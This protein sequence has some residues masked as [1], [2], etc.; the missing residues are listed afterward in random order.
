MPIRT[1]ILALF[2]AAISPQAAT[3]KPEPPASAT[4][5]TT[6]TYHSDAMHFDFIYPSTFASANG[7]VNDALK[8]K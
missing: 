7:M 1:H 4:I 2:P 3:P 5:P 6:T 8:K